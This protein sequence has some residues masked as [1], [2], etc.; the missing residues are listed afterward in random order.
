MDLSLNEERFHGKSWNIIR[1]G[2]STQKISRGRCRQVGNT[3]SRYRDVID[4]PNAKTRFLATGQ[5]TPGDDFLEFRAV[6]PRLGIRIKGVWKI[7][8]LIDTRRKQGCE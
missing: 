6:K 1:V 2:A 5:R 3:T 7:Q 4:P 8:Y